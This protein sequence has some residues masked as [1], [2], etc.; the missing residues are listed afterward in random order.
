MEALEAL[1]RCTDL[2]GVILDFTGW[3]GHIDL[4]S[5]TEVSRWLLE[6]IIA[7]ASSTGDTETAVCRFSHRQS[8]VPLKA[9]ELKE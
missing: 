4:A 6:S 8:S 5:G 1:V 3:E 9:S 7:S 2:A